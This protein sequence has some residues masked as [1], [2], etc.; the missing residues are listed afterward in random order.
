MN[1]QHSARG[2]V[3]GDVYRKVAKAA[4]AAIWNENKNHL[5]IADGNNVGN[6]VIE[7]ITD[8]DIAQ[9]CR[10]YGGARRRSDVASRRR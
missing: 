4:A 3:P 1:D 9:S 5:V 7:E 2:P 8:L 10:G 6:T